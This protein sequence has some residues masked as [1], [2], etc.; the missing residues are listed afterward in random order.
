M[1]EMYKEEKDN[2]ATG[3][4]AVTATIRNVAEFAYQKKAETMLVDEN[5]FKVY[6]V[7]IMTH[8]DE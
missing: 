7:S 1:L 6:F 3:G 4:P 8:P 5:C 2:D